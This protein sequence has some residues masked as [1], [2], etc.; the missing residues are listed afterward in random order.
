M[1]KLKARMLKPWEKH[2]LK[3]MKRQLTNSVNRQD[4]LRPCLHARIILL[5]SN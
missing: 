3:C 1:D 4:G 5:S 2:K